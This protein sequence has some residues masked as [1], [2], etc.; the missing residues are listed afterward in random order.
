MQYNTLSYH[1]L[2]LHRLVAVEDKWNRRLG[3][4]LLRRRG[5]GLFLF[6]R[7]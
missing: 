5:L 4:R 7:E 3:Y 2:L 6:D 1:S